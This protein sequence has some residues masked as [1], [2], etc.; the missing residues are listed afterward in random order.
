VSRPAIVVVGGQTASGKSALAL[1]LAKDLD[2]ELIA[3]DS[4]QVYAGLSIASAGPSDDERSQCAHHLYGAFNPATTT[5]TAGEFVAAADAAMEE[6]VGRGKV[7]IVV[8]GTGLY[9]RS[10]RLGLSPDLPRDEA[11]RR[12]LDGQLHTDGLQALVTQLRNVDAAAAARIDLHNPVRVLRAL[13]IALLGGDAGGRDVDNLLQQP[14]RALLQQAVWWRVE[15]EA[16]VV[17]RAIVR[18]VDAMFTA[19]LVEES[20]ALAERLV[21]EHPLLSTMGTEEALRVHRGEL[22][23]RDAA[24]AIVTRTR[25]YARRQRTWFRKEPWWTPVAPTPRW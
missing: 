8:G 14:P 17:E 9:L 25:Q 6:I 7:A 1:E 19:G 18:R 5:L 13:E 21:P 24:A 4:R 23:V 16:D 3:A 15:P 2:G 11:L 12:R 20:A 22:S 10:L